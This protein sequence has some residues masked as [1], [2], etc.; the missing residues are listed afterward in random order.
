MMKYLNSDKYFRQLIV[1]IISVVWALYFLKDVHLFEFF[2]IAI[3]YFVQIIFYKNS[4]KMKVE[5]K[6]IL[7]SMVLGAG[8]F[9]VSYVIG[10]DYFQKSVQ[11]ERVFDYSSIFIIMVIFFV[12]V[13]TITNDLI[14][15]DKS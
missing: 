11:H 15:S 7:G 4:I 5:F 10:K 1:T 2:I 3:M 6:F 12:F 13:F 14:K 8:Y 9:L